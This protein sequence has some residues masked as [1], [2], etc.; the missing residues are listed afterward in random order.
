MGRYAVG[1]HV[2]LIL[3]TLLSVSCRIIDTPEDVAEYMRGLLTST[4][5]DYLESTTQ[6]LPTRTKDANSEYEIILSQ[7][8]TDF[9]HGYRVRIDGDLR[10]WFT[11]SKLSWHHVISAGELAAHAQ[12]GRLRTVNWPVRSEEIFRVRAENMGFQIITFHKLVLL[13]LKSR[14]SLKGRLSPSRCAAFGRLASRVFYS[15]SFEYC[16]I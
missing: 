7:F 8:R 11:S 15:K 5:S 13:P 3:S 2:L 14:Y 6:V 10:L 12:G 16:E 9:K 1:L 4:K